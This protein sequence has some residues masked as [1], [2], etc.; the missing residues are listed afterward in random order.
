MTIDKEGN[1]NRDQNVGPIYT[2]PYNNEEETVSV[3]RE[4]AQINLD[5]SAQVVSESRE[6]KSRPQHLSQIRL[7]YATQKQK[8]TPYVDRGTAI[9]TCEQQEETIWICLFKAEEDNSIEGI[10]TGDSNIANMNKLFIQ[11]QDEMEAKKIWELS[12]RL[13][14]H[15]EG[16]EEEVVE[17]I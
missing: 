10:S 1:E 16:N 12:K 14:A 11:N 9:A 2:R 8:E 13:G 6:S 15:V 17:K 7:L 5:L 4:L 3:Q